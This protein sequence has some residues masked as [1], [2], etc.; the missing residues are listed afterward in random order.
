[1]IFDPDYT[2]VCTLQHQIE[3]QIMEEVLAEQNIPFYIK[4]FYSDAYDGLFQ[5][6]NGWG[7][8]YAPK[9]YQ[10]EIL[11]ILDDIRNL[12][13]EEFPADDEE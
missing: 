5:L 3:G 6:S 4:S 13:P 7:A 8:V 9:E 12:S 11:E 2:R 1:M 10:G